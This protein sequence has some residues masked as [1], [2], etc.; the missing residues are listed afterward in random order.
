MSDLELRFKIDA[1]SPQTIPMD[2]LGEYLVALAAMLGERTEVHFEK[3][4]PGSTCIVHRI[5]EKVA[6]QV[7]ERIARVARGDAEIVHLNAFKV[8]NELL[9]ADD[10]TGEL[11]FQRGGAQLLKFP[12]KYMPAPPKPEVV[13]QAGTI[14][15]VV[16]KLGGKDKTVPVTVQDGE[17]S[18]RCTTTREVARSLGQHIFGGEL[19]FI[20]TGEWQRP[21]SGGW[22]LAHFIISDFIE[23]DDTPLAELVEALRRSPGTWGEGGDAWDEIREL[24]GEGD[25]AN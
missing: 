15:G 9:K 3:L 20:G 5:E 14:D 25:D 21:E 13:T 8:V 18:Y 12:G 11:S 7:E 23:L 4:E 16:I 1:Y 19:R 22:T 6:P 24:R 10:A 2:R 17:K